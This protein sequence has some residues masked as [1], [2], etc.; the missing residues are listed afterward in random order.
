MK[1]DLFY[2]FCQGA[3]YPFPDGADY[4]LYQE[5]LE[6]AKAADE[7]GFNCLWSV[8]HHGSIEV[9]HM[10]APEMFLTAVAVSTKQLKV[11]H[12]V[13]LTPPQFNH[14]VRIAE[15]AAMLDNLSGGRL[16]FGLGRSTPREWEVFN[17]DPDSTRPVL[18]EVL[19]LLPRLWT[20]EHVSYES[21]WF[22]I[23]PITVVP[24]MLTKP[25]PQMWIAATSNESFEMAAKMGIGVLGLTLFNPLSD[26]DDRL[27][28][29]RAAQQNVDPV[30]PDVINN[31]TGAF[32][33]VYVARTEEEAVEDGA[34]RAAAWYLAKVFAYYSVVPVK[35]GEGG[36]HFQFSREQQLAAIE[37]SGDSP[38][39]QM[40]LNILDEVPVS[41]QEMYDA[42]NQEDQFVMGTPDQVIEKM[43]HHK[44]IGLDHMMCMMQGG[45]SLP[46]EKI[47][48]SIKLMGE[49]VVPHFHDQE[50]GA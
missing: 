1:I 48:A 36:D 14:P 21:E 24:R 19:R 37:A 39:R 38:G 49:T 50:N 27:K 40:L 46:S 15:R 4:R 45:P 8:E 6:Q 41:N 12:S 42:M 32:T 34:P 18:Q 44:A 26:L 30:N 29:Y 3:G 22:S 35:E 13:V 17:T 9:T 28:I 43:E 33:S 16:E 23:R 31:R 20:E 2:E 7:A 10:P 5:V 11:G 25:H 47:V